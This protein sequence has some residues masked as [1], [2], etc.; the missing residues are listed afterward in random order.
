[1]KEGEL[2]PKKKKNPKGKVF[3][4]TLQK[5]GTYLKKNLMYICF[6]NTKNFFS[7]ITDSQP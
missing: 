6:L 7:K 5:S 4:G 2:I 1:M 3:V